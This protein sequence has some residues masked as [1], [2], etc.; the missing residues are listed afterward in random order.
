MRLDRSRRA[1]IRGTCTHQSVFVPRRA[2][3]NLSQHRQWI[4]SVQLSTIGCRGANTTGDSMTATSSCSYNPSY[5]QSFPTDS[6]LFASDFVSIVRHCSNPTTAMSSP[7]EGGKLV[8]RQFTESSLFRTFISSDGKTTTHAIGHRCA[9]S[10][11]PSQMG[12]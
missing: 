6:S 11:P 1:R 2:Y 12:K 5:L 9:T 4:Q 3:D 10:I 8:E 7:N